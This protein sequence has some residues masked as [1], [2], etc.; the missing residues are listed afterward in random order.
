MP[1]FAG[2][3]AWYVDPEN[4]DEWCEALSLIDDHDEMERLATRARQI[5]GQYIPSSITDK[6]VAALL[7]W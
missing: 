3:A 6:T 7:D 1:E 5:A 4:P 2:D